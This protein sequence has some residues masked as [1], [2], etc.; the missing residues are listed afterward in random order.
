MCGYSLAS[1]EFNLCPGDV[2][3]QVR[4]VGLEHEEATGRLVTGFQFIMAARNCC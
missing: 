4:F 2:N 1:W 3:Q